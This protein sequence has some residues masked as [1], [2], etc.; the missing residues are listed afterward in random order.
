MVSRKRS[1]YLMIYAQEEE[2]RVV[3]YRQK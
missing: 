1:V 3:M 2:A